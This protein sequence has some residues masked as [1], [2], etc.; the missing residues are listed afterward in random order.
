MAKRK[1]ETR[2]ENKKQ[3]FLTVARDNTSVGTAVPSKD[4]A[5]F[6]R[7][8]QLKMIALLKVTSDRFAPLGAIW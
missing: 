7:Q 2:G 6:H 5:D 8:P 1:N 3:Q 4:A